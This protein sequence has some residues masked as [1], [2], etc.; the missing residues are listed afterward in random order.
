MPAQPDLLVLG[1]RLRHTRRSRGLTLADLAERTGRPAAYLSRLENGK[2]EPRLGVLSDLAEALGTTTADLLTNSP[3]DRRA[4]LELEL[5]RAQG[6][7]AYRQ[8]DLPVLKPSARL[9]DEVLEHL[10][11][12]GRAVCERAAGPADATESA[13]R[14]NSE[15]RHQMRDRAQLFRRHREHRGRAAGPGRVPRLGPDQRARPYRAG[16][17]LRLPHP[18]RRRP[19][20]HGPLDHRHPRQGDLH[21]RPGRPEGPPGEVGG[22]PDARALR[23]GAFGHL[24][25]RQLPAAADRVELLLSRRC[26]RPRRRRWTC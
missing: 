8:L 9:G 24:G 22:P 15:L 17:Q 12:L 20:P 25:F 26:S 1:R 19:S 23:A 18:A 21:R 16:E 14:A 6:H 7:P 2:V 4:E 5:L 13:R 3:P 10:A 11:G